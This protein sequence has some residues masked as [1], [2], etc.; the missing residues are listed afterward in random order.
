MLNSA[1]SALQRAFMVTVRAVSALTVF[2]V[3]CTGGAA[4]QAQSLGSSG[5]HVGAGG[6]NPLLSP[7]H[8]GPTRIMIV[9]DSIS[10][11]KTGDY[12][13]RYRLHEHLRSQ[14]ARFEFV[15]PYTG[16][17]NPDNPDPGQ[18]GLYRV[19]GW[20]DH[21][22]STWG[23]PL[24]FEKGT[25]EAY[26]RQYRPDLLVVHLGTN[27]FVWFWHEDQ[28]V[29]GN[30]AIVA[31]YMRELIDN[32]RRAKPDVQFLL[33]QIGE[34]SSL[35]PRGQPGPYNQRLTRLREQLT[36]PHS[37]VEL[38]DVAGRWDWHTDTY[39]GTHPNARGEYVIMQAVASTLWSQWHYGGPFPDIPPGVNVPPAPEGVAVTPRHT[40]RGSPFT[41]S[42]A[43]VD[44]PGIWTEYKVQ[45]R[46][47]R[48]YGYGLVW[49]SP[50]TTPQLSMAYSGPALPINGVY[51][52][53]VVAKDMYGLESTSDPVP[54]TIDDKAP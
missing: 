37:K 44:N 47:H 52:V 20:H 11:G 22:N 35:D 40:R 6:S 21:H 9:G 29:E 3:L 42:W 10:H 4:P 48:A 39:D 13:W 36:Q 53:V 23:R 50:R 25:I 45:V 2:A 32:A 19:G 33:A 15:G 31:G 16:P 27:D 30:T 43:R 38:A 1:R 46:Y 49:E 51:H 26:V 14:A 8:G 54:L 17:H 34:A 18:P 12:T 7:P 41:V 24:G 28:S 5:P